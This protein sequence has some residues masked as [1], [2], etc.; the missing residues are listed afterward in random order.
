MDIKAPAEE[1]VEAIRIRAEVAIR[2]VV[3]SNARAV[4]ETKAIITNLESRIKIRTTE[5]SHP[6]LSNSQPL[7]RPR[8]PATD[9]YLS[10]ST[11]SRQR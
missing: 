6:L 3:G 7:L 10:F 9:K 11:R 8:S 5:H 1:V 2:V 4:V